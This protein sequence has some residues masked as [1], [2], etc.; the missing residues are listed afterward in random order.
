MIARRLARSRTPWVFVVAA[1]AVP[2]VMFVALPPGAAWAQPA[3]GT[4]APAKDLGENIKTTNNV[5]PFANQIQDFVND[6]VK[7]LGGSDPVEQS[8][9][10]EDL[11]RQ[12]EIG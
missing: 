1:V 8:R 5:G 10:R 6:R 4:A 7:A 3:T 9:D 2:G 12:V 11:A